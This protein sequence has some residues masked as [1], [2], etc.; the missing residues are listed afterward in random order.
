MSGITF[1]VKGNVVTVSFPLD[2]NL[3]LS[4]SGKSQMVATTHGNVNIP[5]T[6]ITIGVNAYRKASKAQAA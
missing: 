3:G 1:A 2:A 5:G 6:D 4:A